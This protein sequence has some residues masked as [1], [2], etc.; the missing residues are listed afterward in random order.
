MV[1]RDHA[2]HNHAFHVPEGVVLSWGPRDRRRVRRGPVG[3]TEKGRWSS[4]S[5]WPTNR[6]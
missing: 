3:I 5:R 2:V 4:W 6:G 1:Q